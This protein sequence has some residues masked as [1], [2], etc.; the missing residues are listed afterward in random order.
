[1]RRVYFV[2]FVRQLFS[3]FAIK[4]M[5]VALLFL[6][7]ARRVSVFSVFH[8]APSLTALSDVSRF[9]VSAFTNTGLMVQV[10]VVGVL[11]F[12]IW[13]VLDMVKRGFALTATEQG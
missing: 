7:M 12:G 8:N 6:N 13:I 1:M 5:A 4:T 2:Y 11:F 9:F 3:P 10:S